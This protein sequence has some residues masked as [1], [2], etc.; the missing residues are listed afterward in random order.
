MGF[1][2]WVDKAIAAI[3]PERALRRRVARTRLALSSQYRGADQNRLLADWILSSSGSTPGQWE[4][5][6]LRERSRD[7]NRNDPIASGTSD[8]MTV[9]IVGQGLTPQSKISAEMIGL[10][11]ERAS[12]LQ[13]KAE[14]VWVSWCSFADSANKLNFDEIQFLAIRKII[15]DGEVFALPV[16]A[17]EM[18][19]PLARAV[20]LMES[21]RCQS[22]ERQFT[23][24]IRVGARGQPIEY[25][26]MMPSAGSSY[27]EQY[28]KIQ[29]RD[30]KGRFN[31]LHVFPTKRPGQLRGVP[32]FAPAMTYFKHLADYLEAEVVSARVAA[33]LSIFITAS[34]PL[35]MAGL[36][37]T[38]PQTDGARVQGVEPGMVQYLGVGE[39]INVV[40]PKRPG[41]AFAPFLEGVL[42]LIGVSLGLPYELIFKDFSKTNYSSARAALLEGRRQFS[43]WR[44]WFAKRFCQP[45][46]ELV[47]E[48]AY[49]RGQF[50][51]PDFYRFKTEYCRAQWIGGAWGWVDPVKEVE[52]SRLAID[53]GLSTLAEECAGQARDWEEV[54]E[55][56]K[57]EQARE[58]EL[59]IIIKSSGGT[60]ATPGR[61]EPENAKTQEE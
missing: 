57:R 53:Y 26:F 46:W 36:N 10:D 41:D 50:D 35:G 27:G 59:G 14:N 20:E 25:S 13:K 4:L 37:Q 49:L 54:L 47:L 16:W 42:R 7:L 15:E 12:D 28:R 38:T 17:D 61:E 19:R 52:A 18:W 39:S 30:S 60:R 32:F 11:E 44:N 3:S 51:A 23:H 24:G 29:A 5:S 48:E 43:S 40:D 34:D 9:N 56:R 8:T 22:S 31:V 58:K 55:Q 33:C 45:I 6:T 2:A 1:S 21:D